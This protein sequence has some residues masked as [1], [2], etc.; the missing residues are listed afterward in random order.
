MENRVSHQRLRWAVR[1]SALAVLGVLGIRIWFPH[2]RSVGIF[3]RLPSATC[4]ADVLERPLVFRALPN[5]ELALG[6]DIM[7]KQVAM[8]RLPS[9]GA[10]SY[11]RTLLFYADPSLSSQEVAEILNDVRAQVPRWDIFVITP[12]SNQPCEQWLNAHSGPAA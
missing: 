2:H 9:L 3:L 10:A 6:T 7:P 11:K 4:S 1:A 12:S 5:R 8:A